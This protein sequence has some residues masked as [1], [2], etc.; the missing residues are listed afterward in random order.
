MRGFE[1]LSDIT[2]FPNLV[3]LGALVV[4]VR[5][6]NHL[7]LALDQVNAG[8]VGKIITRSFN[9]NHTLDPLPIVNEALVP[10]DN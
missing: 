6:L 7:R 8:W 2:S 5:T 9:E 1:V 3:E 10:T 4:K